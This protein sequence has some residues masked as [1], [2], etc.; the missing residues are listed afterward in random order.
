MSSLVHDFSGFRS[1]SLLTISP[2]ISEPWNSSLTV[3]LRTARPVEA[4]STQ[5]S[6]A[7]QDSA[8]FGDAV[9]SERGAKACVVVAFESDPCSARQCSRR[10]PSKARQAGATRQAS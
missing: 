2:A 10:A 9:H 1:G 4:R 7:C 3:G 8:T 5:A 6:L